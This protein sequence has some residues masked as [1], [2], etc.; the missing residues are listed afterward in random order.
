MTRIHDSVVLAPSDCPSCRHPRQYLCEKHLVAHFL[1][2]PRTPMNSLG[3]FCRH[4]S[5]DFFASSICTMPAPSRILT[6]T[7]GRDSASE[8]DF[9]CPA[10]DFKHS[11]MSDLHLVHYT[12]GCQWWSPTMIF[13]CKDPVIYSWFIDNRVLV[14]ILIFELCHLRYLK[15]AL[16]H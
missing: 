8:T 13:V 5:R 11:I 9:A 4:G 2:V 1:R 14:A 10:N 16:L 3:A 15:Y 12:I 6:S 7:A